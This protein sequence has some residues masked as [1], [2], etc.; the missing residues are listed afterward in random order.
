MREAKEGREGREKDQ[1]VGRRV[2]RRRGEREESSEGEQTGWPREGGP[3]GPGQ[4]RKCRLLWV[5]EASSRPA[6]SRQVTHPQAPV[7]AP[8]VS[9]GLGGPAAGPEE[10]A[11]GSV[12]LCALSACARAMRLTSQAGS[13]RREVPQ[14]REEQRSPGAGLDLEQ[15]PQRRATEMPLLVHPVQVVHVAREA[16]P[17][18]DEL[19]AQRTRVGDESV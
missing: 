18:Q 2:R 19:Q 12:T 1:E 7:R 4:A 8:A 13:S 16:Q 3:S 5:A 9:Q 10:K 14:E 15:V 6:W 11:V 17:A